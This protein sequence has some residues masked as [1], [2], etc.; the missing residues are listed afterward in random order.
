MTDKQTKLIN[1][2]LSHE[3]FYAN[4]AGDNG[5]ETYMGISRKAFPRW[6]GW[7]IVDKSKPLKYNQHIKDNDLDNMVRRLYFNNFYEPLHIDEI[8]SMEISAHL[9][10]HSVNAGIKPGVKLLQK[11]I[12]ASSK[13]K[14][15][16]DGILGP[17]TLET[18]ANANQEE[19]VENIIFMRNQFYKDIV[20]RKPAQKKFLKGWLNRVSDTTHKV[21]PSTI[22]LLYTQA[23]QEGWIPKILGFIYDTMQIFKGKGTSGDEIEN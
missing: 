5:G 17:L 13:S 10:D 1:L 21:Q 11:A 20:A 8:Q 2:V 4:V 9:L 18:L 3:G 22:S 14:L 19:V 15:K 12:N 7:Q 16:V 6:S 23:K